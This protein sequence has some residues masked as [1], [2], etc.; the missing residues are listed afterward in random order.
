MVVA[1]LAVVEAGLVVEEGLVVVVAG[2]SHF[3]C[4]N[5]LNFVSIKREFYHI[6]ISS[7]VQMQAHNLHCLR[8][9]PRLGHDSGFRHERVSDS[10]KED[11]GGGRNSRD[12]EEVI[13]PSSRSSVS[14]SSRGAYSSARSASE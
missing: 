4:F 10:P 1:G 14:A 8:K 12:R 5:I 2:R 13:A 7:H 6:H 11:G 3:S 9:G